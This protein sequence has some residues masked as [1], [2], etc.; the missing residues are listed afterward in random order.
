MDIK[1]RITEELNE[2][3]VKYAKKQ[4]ITRAEAIRRSIELTL[5]DEK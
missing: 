5:K 2:K 1:V 4:D 3:L